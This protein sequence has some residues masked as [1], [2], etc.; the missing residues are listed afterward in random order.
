MERIERKEGEL[1]ILGGY[2]FGVAYCRDR[3]LVLLVNN[4]ADETA[5]D[6]EAAVRRFQAKLDKPPAKVDDSGN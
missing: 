6:V 4:L 1:L 3:H 2:T 5:A